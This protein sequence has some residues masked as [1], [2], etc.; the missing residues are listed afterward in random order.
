M[1]EAK[2]QQCQVYTVGEVAKLLRVD[3]TTI[4]RWAQ[5]GALQEGLDFFV[6]PNSGKRRIIRFTEAQYQQ[7]LD[8]VP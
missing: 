3:S 7:I 4:R 1:Q 6:L 5:N 2:P 8:H